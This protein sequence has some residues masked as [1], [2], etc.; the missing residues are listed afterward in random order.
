MLNL[1]RGGSG[2]S[3]VLGVREAGRA[4]AHHG[5]KADAGPA[6]R[7]AEAGVQRVTVGEKLRLPPTPTAAAQ[8][9]SAKDIAICLIVAIA[10]L[11]LVMTGMAGQVSLPVMLLVHCM[12]MLGVTLV[13]DQR[14]RSRMD[15]RVL[16][17]AVVTTAVSGPLGAGMSAL[18]GIYLRYRKFETAL[19]ANW[20]E[21]ISG[22]AR[23]DPVVELHERIQAGRTLN[24]YVDARAR[25]GAILRSGP[26]EE[27]Q[28]VLSV[29]T[30]KY[31]PRF[32]GLLELALRNQDPPIRVQAA[33]VVARLKEHERLK[34]R[35]LTATVEDLDQREVAG[36][37]RTAARITASLESGLLDEQDAAAARLL[38]KSLC[39]AALTVE[40]GHAQASLQL[41]WLLM[42]ET[43]YGA[44]AALLQPLVASGVSAAHAPLRDC[45]IHLRRYVEAAAIARM[46]LPDPGERSSEP[47][48]HSDRPVSPVPLPARSELGDAA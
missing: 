9:Q 44:A 20:Y 42:G 47:P 22:H 16:A 46:S 21:R 13:L 43:A 11:L 38:A 8:D 6:H 36:R 39:E 26:L 24:P 23:V 30:Q 27:K 4:M 5:E 3:S 41:A 31:H 25:F 35:S 2:S 1:P 28:R 15:S 29:I 34:V 10:E 19:L 12:I 7:E 37:L 33:A 40:P 48:L 18:L 17:V 32:A 45:F 14:E